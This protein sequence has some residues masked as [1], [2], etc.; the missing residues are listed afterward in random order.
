MPTGDLNLTASQRAH[1]DA[2]IR[3]A[4]TLSRAEF[5][6]YLGN[7][8]DDTAAFA[9]LLHRN[10]TLPARSVLVLV[11]PVRRALEIVVG[12][13]VR[14]RITDTE[15][16]VAALHLRTDLAAGDAAGGL[17]R[18]VTMLAEHAKPQRVL[19]TATPEADEQ[20]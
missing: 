17:V 19:H 9:R 15:I 1:V 13:W 11:D 4:E 5:S 8:A 20:A 7:S 12:S 18:C 2:A 10:L 6:V 16:E 3:H 14:Q